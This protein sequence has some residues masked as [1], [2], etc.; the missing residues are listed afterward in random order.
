MNLLLFLLTFIFGMVVLAGFMGSFRKP[1]IAHE[2]MPGYTVLGYSY[3][4]SYQKIGPSIRKVAE[5]AKSKG[6]EPQIVAIYFDNPRDVKDEECR[7]LAAIR[8]TT[9]MAKELQKENLTSLDIPPGN[10]WVCH[11]KGSSLPTRIMG[12]MRTYPSIQK[13]IMEE[14][15]MEKVTFVY[16][17]YEPKE[18]IFVMQYNNQA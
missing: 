16:E 12:A 5:L 8:V 17:V 2:K 11:W 3:T 6:W 14:Q 9:E 4:G 15:L 7:A 10:A 13:K 1:R 18:T